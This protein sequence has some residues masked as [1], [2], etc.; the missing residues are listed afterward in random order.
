MEYIDTD[1]LLYFN[2][3]PRELCELEDQKWLP[4]VDWANRSHKLALR[5]TYTLVDMPTIPDDSRCKLQQY[6]L[7]MQF[8]EL[9]AINYGV[10]AIKSVLLML[11]CLHNHLDTQTASELSNL[12]QRYQT[13]VYKKVCLLY[14]CFCYCVRVLD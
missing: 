6:F 13:K 9:T 11:A 7:R 8:A 1:T 4:I 12:E 14:T 5:P 10:D 2:D 3:S